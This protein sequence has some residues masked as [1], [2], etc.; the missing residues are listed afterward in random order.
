MPL[1]SD[2]DGA[3]ATA[4]GVY[5]AD[6]EIAIASTFVVAKGGQ[7]A[8]RYIGNNKTDRASIDNILAAATR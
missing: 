3:A 1:Y 2:D 7:I 4:Y 5:D 6:T 8:F